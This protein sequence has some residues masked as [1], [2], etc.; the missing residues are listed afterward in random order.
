MRRS[1]R[2]GGVLLCFL[3][4]LLL[5]LEW[6]VPAVVLLVLHFVIDI[7]AWWFV[8][9]LALWILIVFVE[10]AVISWVARCDTG[11]DRQRENKNPYSSRNGDLF[12]KE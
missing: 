2:S 1:K 6:A 4:N 5:N 3:L 11:S 7:S 9:A 8:S 10:T 12:K